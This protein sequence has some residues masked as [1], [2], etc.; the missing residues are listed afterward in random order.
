M[1]EKILTKP[2]SQNNITYPSQNEKQKSHP[3]LHKIVY[4]AKNNLLNLTLISSVF[5]GSYLAKP[6]D[7]TK[8]YHSGARIEYVSPSQ[9]PPDVLGMYDPISHTINI[10]NNLPSRELQFVQAHESGHASGYQDELKTDGFASARV[11]YNI[12][13]F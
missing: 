12:R 13:P 9:L 7:L 5:L 4:Y 8:D 2:S 6:Q 10:A 1:L 11:G 3:L